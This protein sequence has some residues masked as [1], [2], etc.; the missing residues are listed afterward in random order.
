MQFSL[1]VCR[2]R[3]LRKY[4]AQLSMTTE[5][6]SRLRAQ[7][8]QYSHVPDKIYCGV[9]LHEHDAAVAVDRMRIKLCSDPQYVEP[10]LNVRPYVEPCLPLRFCRARSSV[11]DVRQQH[12]QMDV[13]C[14][15]MSR[16]SSA[17]TG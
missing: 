12:A 17:F 2:E 7:G 10:Y 15:S 9:Y 6:R 3:G 1:F 11:P 4:Q 14:P 5:L 16:Q 13:A 8:D